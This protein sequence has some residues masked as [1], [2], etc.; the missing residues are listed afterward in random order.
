ML[1]LPVDDGGWGRMARAE[2]QKKW[3]KKAKER[4]R[5][6]IEVW[7]SEEAIARLD[8]LVGDSPHHAS[9]AD[10]IEYLLLG[11]PGGVSTGRVAASPDESSVEAPKY[12]L[13]RRKE[14]GWYVVVNGAV[15][16]RVCRDSDQGEW[17]AERDGVGAPLWAHHYKRQRRKDAV[18][19]MLKV[20]FG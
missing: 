15:V 16:G 7:L 3:A 19:I 8:A 9:R 20:E 13:R 12:R 14:G 17:V 4:G 1:C 11:D 2:D 10:M 18:E 5:R 6:R